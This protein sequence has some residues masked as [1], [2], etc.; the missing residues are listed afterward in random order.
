M[1]SV[2]KFAQEAAA[3]EQWLLNGTD[4]DADAA[5]AGLIRL[6]A[7]YGAGIDLSPEWSDDLEGR[8]DVE[9]VSDEEWRMAYEASGRLPLDTYSEVFDPTAVAGEEPVVGSVSDD[10]ADVCREVVAG[11]RA[12]NLGDRAGAVWEW[13]GLRDTDGIGWWHEASDLHGHIRLGRLR[14]RR[15]PRAFTRITRST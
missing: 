10:L 1:D 11:L 7:L 2:V 6:V 3:F 5:R 4:R 12:C 15:I 13:S 9:C 8:E 14:G